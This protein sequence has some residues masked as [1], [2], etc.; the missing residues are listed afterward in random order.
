MRVVYRQQDQVVNVNWK[1][2]SK[3][4]L[5]L[6]INGKEEPLRIIV[7]KSIFSNGTI[8]AFKDGKLCGSDSRYKLGHFKKRLLDFHYHIKQGYEE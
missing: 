5:T 8:A 2:D 4:D 1:A 6:Y 7:S 3:G